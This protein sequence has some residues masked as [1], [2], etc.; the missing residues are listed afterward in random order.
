MKVINKILVLIISI[1]ILNS[2]GGGGSVSVLPVVDAYDEPESTNAQMDILWVVDPSRSMRQNVKSVSDNIESFIADFV[3]KGYDFRM[4]VIST[5]AWSKRAYQDNNSLPIELSSV[6]GEFHTGECIGN[7]SGHPYLEAGSFSSTDVYNYTD[8]FRR[9]FDVYG[10]AL[11]TSGCG[12]NHS[13]GYAAVT[14]NIFYSLDNV[15]RA[16]IAKYVN[17]ERPAQ[18]VQTF[19]EDNGASFL[20]PDAFLAI[21]IISDEM[22]ASRTDLTPTSAYN[23]HDPTNLTVSS[24]VSTLNALKDNDPTKY[25]VY[26]I[27]NKSLEGSDNNLAKRLA[28]AT[29]GIEF[30]IAASMSE[31]QNNLNQIKGNIISSSSM[32]IFKREPN[33]A[34]IKVEIVRS[35]GTVEVPKANPPGSDGW[36]FDPNYGDHGAIFFAGEEYIPAQGE[37]VIVGFTPVNLGGG[38]K[39]P[40]LNIDNNEVDEEQGPGITV[41]TVKIFNKNVGPNDEVLFTIDPP[42]T[43]FSIDGATGALTTLVNLDAEDKVIQKVTVEATITHKDGSGNTTGTTT[44]PARTLNIRVMD[45]ADQIPLAN[46]AALEYDVSSFDGSHVVVTGIL[47]RYV[48]QMDASEAHT[49]SFAAL[50]SPATGESINVT[51]AQT[52]AFTYTIPKSSIVFDGSGKFER[53]IPYTVQGSDH[54]YPDPHNPTPANESSNDLI[55]T[56]V[57]ENLPPEYEVSIC[58]GGGYDYCDGVDNDVV[59]PDT[60]GVA[61]GRIPLTGPDVSVSGTSSGNKDDLV[62]I[63]GEANFQSA[64]NPAGY[65]EVT[66]AFPDSKM[67]EV[68]CVRIYRDDSS[69]LGNAIYQVLTPQTLNPITREVFPIGIGTRRSNKGNTAPAGAQGACASLSDS[70]FTIYTDTKLIGGGVRVLRPSGAKNANGHENL[71][72][73]RIEV[74]GIEARYNLIDLG[75]HFKD[76]EDDAAN[77]DLTYYV[78]D[79]FGEGPGPGWATINDTTL[80]LLPSASV[81]ETIGIIAIDSGGK[82]AFTTI[83]VVGSGGASAANAAPISLLTLDDSKRGGLSMRRWGGDGATP[84]PASCTVPSGKNN[85]VHHMEIDNF[86][87]KPFNAATGYY[88]I[89]SDPV[90]AAHLGDTYKSEPEDGWCNEPVHEDNKYP[91]GSS[92]FCHPTNFD[93]AANRGKIIPC[94]NAYRSYGEIYSGYFVPAETGVYKF[95]TR[96]I[97]N[98]IMLRVAPTEYYEDTQKLF[99]ANWVDADMEAALRSLINYPTEDFASTAARNSE[100]AGTGTGTSLTNYRAIPYDTKL[101]YDLSGITTDYSDGYIYLKQGNVYAFEMRFGEGGGGV[102]FDFEYNYKALGGAWTGWTPMDASVV[103]PDRGP[104]A[105][106]PFTITATGGAVNFNASELFYDAEMDVLE[107]TARLVNADGTAFGHSIEDIGLSLNL[108]TGQ[109]SGTLAGPYTS[110]SEKPRIVIK[111]KERRTGGSETESLP[112]KFAE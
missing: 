60:E 94:V 61:F 37:E 78:T 81:N 68:G 23:P 39:A 56:I 36:T 49:F 10:L 35:T 72:L 103:V 88:D 43:V 30:D 77:L 38:S 105:H 31:Y 93:S 51:N 108:L 41:G 19:L 76:V 17:D 110:A 83:K 66:I 64:A 80:R 47:S 32:Y 89:T 26:T 33:P 85:L 91:L 100:F 15:T 102:H 84:T 34:A 109:L 11:G 27:H 9:N 65:H 16:E 74:Y 58:P 71:R 3:T 5:A 25:A 53:T 20:R 95:R 87:E 112:I 106:T 18:S 86:I 50:S 96:L 44:I 101:F 1:V 28:E 2:C 69:S 40:Y 7:T 82:E 42:S 13:T 67:Y 92:T 54:N 8:R 46:V 90:Q 12:L 75:D 4:G 48:S 107:Y 62:A 22:D 24:I 45:I 57:E 73:D 63:S 104:N 99:I 55:I 97:D 111:A 98:T 21:I 70:Y 59:R 29:G 14:G 79:A 52:G 6:L